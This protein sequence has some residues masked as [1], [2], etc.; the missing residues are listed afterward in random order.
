MVAPDG[1]VP[2]LHGCKARRHCS[3]TAEANQQRKKNHFIIENN[4]NDDY[5]CWRAR[6][7]RRRVPAMHV[8]IDPEDADAR[9]RRL[10]RRYD[11]L[12]AAALRLPESPELLLQLRL[13]FRRASRAQELAHVGGWS[14]V[15]RY[16]V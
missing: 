4:F 10:A 14:A 13:L 16:P 5:A 15:E 7:A 1:V 8:L 6:V 12:R 2:R 9:I 11:R 3:G